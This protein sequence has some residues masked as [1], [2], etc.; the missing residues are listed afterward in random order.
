MA[1]HNHEADF[2]QLEVR[3]L[4]T[5]MKLQAE[6]SSATLREIFDAET[7]NSTVSSLIGFAEV[8]STLYKQRRRALPPLPTD[9]AS[10]YEALLDAPERFRSCEGSAASVDGGIAV[11]FAHP[12][13][14]QQLRQASTWCMDGTFRTVPGAFYQLLTVGFIRYDTFWPA[15]Y[16][17]LNRKTA[18]LYKAALTHLTDQLVPLQTPDTVVTDYE[19]ALITAAEQVFPGVTVAG[20]WFHYCQAVVGKFKSNGLQACKPEQRYSSMDAEAAGSPT[21]AG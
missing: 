4:K 2:E 8:E 21:A 14:L 19:V 9:A 15:V 1:E 10:V 11:F 17:L 18:A 13:M 12:D 7:R 5:R 20:C 3:S 6:E 16:I